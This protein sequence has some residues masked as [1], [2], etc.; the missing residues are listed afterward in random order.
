MSCYARLSGGQSWCG[1]AAPPPRRSCCVTSTCVCPPGRLLATESCQVTYDESNP[2]FATP[3]VE[4]SP[5]MPMVVEVSEA[6]S[7]WRWSWRC[8][9]WTW[10][11]T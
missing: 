7:S 9:G 11:S 2:D 1:S 6:P 5:G 4:A 3:I 10:Q 8:A